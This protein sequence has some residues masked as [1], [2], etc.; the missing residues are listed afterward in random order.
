MAYNKLTSLFLLSLFLIATTSPLAH[1][2][3][4]NGQN[5]IGLRVRGLLV[6]SATGNPPGPGIAGVN[7]KISCNG[8]STS[9]V[10]VLTDANGY[11]QTIITALDGILFDQTTTPC[12]VIIDTPIASCSLL[13]STGTLRAP[14]TL[15][16]TLI[17]TLLGLVADATCGAFHLVPIA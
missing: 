2:V 3:L 16:G 14:I 1:G 4:I 5:V 10:Q 17:Q 8:G 13:A 15:V 9:L 6:C 11:F 7:V 12:Q